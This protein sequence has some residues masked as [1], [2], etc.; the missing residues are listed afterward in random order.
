MEQKGSDDYKRDA[1]KI[2]I[3]EYIVLY[4]GIILISLHMGLSLIHI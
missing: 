1:L 4:V 2:S 3:I